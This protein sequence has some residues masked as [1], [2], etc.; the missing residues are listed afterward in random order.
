MKQ[1]VGY[2][3]ASIADSF[4]Q[5][6][7][8][9]IYRGR[10]NNE[11]S[12]DA[13]ASKMV[14]GDETNAALDDKDNIDNRNHD[15]F[16]KTSISKSIERIRD[17]Q[18]ILELL[19]DTKLAIEIIIGTI[20]SPKDLMAP[21][22]TFKLEGKTFDH[23]VMPIVTYIEDYFK[24]TYKLE[25]Q[26]EE[27]LWDILGRRGSYPIAILPETAVDY[28]INSNTNVTLESVQHHVYTAGN[29]EMA[30]M[31]YLGHSDA[32]T[33]SMEHLSLTDFIS[34][35][36]ADTP[37]PSKQKVGPDSFLLDVLD[38]FDFL[39]LPLLRNKIS[40]QASSAAV[41]KAR[42]TVN[43][44]T[45]RDYTVTSLENVTLSIGNK[46]RRTEAER[47]DLAKLYPHR[48]FIHTPIQRV[49]GRD[50]L[51]R[52]TV[53][54]PLT[55]RIPTEAC[56]PVY[57]PYD[58]KE[59]IGY[60]IALDNVGN[61]I[62]L[63][64][65]DNIHRM[66][67]VNSNAVSNG[68]M[69]SHLL[70]SATN[71]QST[72]SNLQGINLI[73]GI[74]RASYVYQEVVEKQLLEK[75]ARGTVGTGY[76]LG[77]LDVPMSL[78]MARSLAGKRTQLLYVP[79]EVLAYL[80][81]DF[82]DSGLGK[83]LLDDGKLIASMRS[84][85]L[86]VNSMASTKNAITKRVLDIALDPAEK[87]PQKAVATIIQEYVKGTQGDY[88]LTNN[89]VDQINYLQT[90]GVMVRTQE[91]P[92][93]PNT[94]VGVDY[95]DNQYK[96]IDVTYDELL[97]KLHMQGIGLPTEIIEGAGAVD[98]AAQ[99]ILSNVLTA[100]RIAML[101]RKFTTPLSEF[102]RK[103]IYN[104]AVLTDGI[105]KLMETNG[106]KLVRSNGEPLPP[107]ET[108]TYFIRALE[109]ELPSPDTTK[110]KEQREAYDAQSD[111]Y[112]EALKNFLSEEWLSEA[113][114]GELGGS[115]TIMRTSKYLKA[116]F[117]RKWMK[118]NNVCGE[119]FDVIG[120]DVTGKPLIDFMAEKNDHMEGLM[121]SLK[122]MMKADMKRS[123][124]I[125]N[126]ITTYGE[127]LENPPE[128]ATNAPPSD[129]SSP[130]DDMDTFDG[131]ADVDGDLGSLDEPAGD[132]LA[133]LDTDMGKLD[134]S[135][136]E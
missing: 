90:A 63:S 8:H 15:I 70:Q 37:K 7:A 18:N 113:E 136:D 108:L 69:V 38:N 22:L 12:F 122:P 103:Y 62:R 51:D 129:T 132:D 10:Q 43:S 116:H 39:K 107:G 49:R 115:D 46:D 31:G 60:F 59:H 106:I 53:G 66:L 4:R 110:I 16:V 118:S 57:T 35:T 58:T 81:V 80:A 72:G 27:M 32:D 47:A 79:S 78:M 83:T 100:R 135:K 82:D 20:L 77:N 61:P 21:T 133:D 44:E 5:S 88:P 26:L 33:P 9:S 102:V 17:N 86:V 56:I 30:G 11:D 124:E 55:L 73:D 48:D 92:R 84:M 28:L 45:L 104:S 19:P 96:P 109:V 85:N 3:T 29:G 120:S 42:Q 127:K 131:S 71:H 95:L 75:I 1:Q 64:E 36:L 114:L 99:A 98:F 125:T 130:S 119:V 121:Q 91:H 54:H 67:T 24:N 94:N 111:F 74:D 65:I 23:R 117:M 13:I 112:E 126:D 123:G 14:K 6:T 87:N 25:D 93:L 68:D 34:H 89:P 40:K 97:K 101:S 76:S 105:C 128:E 134:E 41:L 2:N 52:E 50:A